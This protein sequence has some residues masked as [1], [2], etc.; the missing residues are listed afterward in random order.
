MLGNRDMLKWFKEEF[1]RV[2]TQETP[3][4]RDQG[5]E[6][7][8]HPSVGMSPGSFLPGKRD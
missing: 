6:N 1:L 7:E 8:F 2:D 3:P 5:H 4:G